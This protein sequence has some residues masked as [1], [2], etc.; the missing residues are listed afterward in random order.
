MSSI[1]APSM[2]NDI[3]KREPAHN[4]IQYRLALIM[5]SQ[6]VLITVS[7]YLSFVLRLD[8]DFDR[9]TRLLFWHT[10]P[11]VIVVKLLMFYYFGLLR[12]WWRYVGMSDLLNIGMANLFSS[13]FLYCTIL[14]VL[15]PLGFPRSVI[16]I[17]MALSVLFVAGARFGVR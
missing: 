2:E 10:V 1:T 17:D 8:T 12:G 7:Y 5:L 4:F 13:S 3:V 15:H 6:M 11:L 14:L 9:V 16:P